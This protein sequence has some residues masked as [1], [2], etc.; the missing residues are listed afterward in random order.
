MVQWLRLCR[1][2][3]GE[4]V[5]F[6]VQEL[7]LHVPRGA[8]NKFFLKCLLAYNKRLN[9]I[10]LPLNQLCDVITHFS[11]SPRS[12]PGTR[13]FSPFSD[14]QALFCTGPLHML[15]P[16]PGKSAPPSLLHSQS[17]PQGGRPSLTL[18]KTTP[19][20]SGSQPSPPSLSP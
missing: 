16:L 5:R 20:K 18:P 14:T 6:L 3:Q 1:P 2:I 8:A 10:S 9:Y 17:P 11:P 7:R 13:A 4:Q 15:F 12:A 19:T